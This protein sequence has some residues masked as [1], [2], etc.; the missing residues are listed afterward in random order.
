MKTSCLA[1]YVKTGTEIE[2][3]CVAEYYL[4]LDIIAQFMLMHSLDAAH[5]AY[6]HEYRCLDHAVDGRYS[7]CPGFTALAGR[8]E[9]KFQRSHLM[10]PCFL[11][12]FWMASSERATCSLVCVAMRE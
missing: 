7:T 8:F 2:M 1:K 5:S 10:M 9:F 12:T 4:G 6:R 3:I 11:N